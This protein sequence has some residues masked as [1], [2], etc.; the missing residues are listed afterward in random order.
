MN[1]EIK[2]LIARGFAVFPVGRES[3]IPLVKWRAYA[4]TNE[5]DAS[6]LFSKHADANIGIRLGACAAGCIVV[7]DTD[8]PEALA[9]VSYTH[10]TLPTSDLV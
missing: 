3:K 5:A 10:L 2:K 4:A 6:A 9:A 1:S 7:V 8:G